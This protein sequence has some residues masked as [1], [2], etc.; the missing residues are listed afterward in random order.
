MRTALALAQTFRSEILLVH[1][2]P[3]IHDSP[4]G[5]EA[6]KA[7]PN[8]RLQDLRSKIIASGIRVAD[9]IVTVGSP[10]NEI[11][12]LADAHDV[13]VIIVGSGEQRD[14]SQFRLGLT[15]E[16][17]IRKARKPVWVVKA[18]A[19]GKFNTILCPVDFSDPARRALTNAI[20]LARTFQARLL[21]LTVIQ[22][23]A[24]IYISS[25]ELADEAQAKYTEAQQ[26]QFEKFLTDFDFHNVQW[27][28]T[29]RHGWP[30]QEILTLAR[31]QSADL[32]V[33]GSTG[34]TGLAR[35]LMGSVAEEVIREMPCSVITVKAEHAVRLRVEQEIVGLKAHVTKGHELL[36]GG[37]AP[38]ALREFQQCLDTDTLYVPAWEG[39]AAAHHRLGH[40]EESERCRQTAQCARESLEYSR[41]QA[42]VRAEH[43]L[44]RRKL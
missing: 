42:A 12:E 11:I 10:F 13:N 18:G 17:L 23:L 1:V 24:T 16:K 26:Q 2:I 32:L 15:A 38:E 6:L 37:F 33:M 43:W 36:E 34:R 4:V 7:A 3:E 30:H 22:P 20:H 41:I 14:E 40:M 27:T 29:V 9:P 5:L 35:I 44:W 21:V 8:R 28:K 39:L 25:A 31:E 19:T